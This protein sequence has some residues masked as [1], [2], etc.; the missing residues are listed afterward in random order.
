ME[1]F[2][3]RKTFQYNG[4]NTWVND[5]SCPVFL[6]YSASSS[7]AVLISCL[8]KSSFD[9]NKQKIDIIKIILILHITLDVAQYILINLYNANTET[10]QVNILGKLQNLLKNLDNFQNKY[11]IFDDN[12]NIILY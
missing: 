10:E 11:M 5:F 2:F 12:F 6:F 7:C 4:E 3:T 9:L 1:F 8:H